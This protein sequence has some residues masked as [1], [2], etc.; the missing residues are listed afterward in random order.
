MLND[1]SEF[2][3]FF[4]QLPIVKELKKLRDDLRAS[5]EALASTFPI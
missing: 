5:N 2:K 3:A 1:E 4:D